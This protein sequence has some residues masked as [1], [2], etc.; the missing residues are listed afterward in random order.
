MEL[1]T[2]S[3]EENFSKDAG[4]GEK[5]FRWKYKDGNDGEQ[6]MKLCLLVL[7]QLLLQGLVPNR[8]WTGTSLPTRGWGP[9]YMTSIFLLDICFSLTYALHPRDCSMCIWEERVFYLLLSG[10]FYRCLFALIGLWYCSSFSISLLI[11][12]PVVLSIIK[13]V[14]LKCSTLTVELFLPSIL[15]IFPSYIF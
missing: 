14:V 2:T 13:N 5:W 12:C 8:T 11:F 6:Q 1:G 3:V 15:S 10:V 7:A 9:Q 4:R